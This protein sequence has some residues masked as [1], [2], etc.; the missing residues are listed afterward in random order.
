MGESE[1]DAFT[2]A[3]FEG[4]SVCDAPE[5]TGGF[6]NYVGDEETRGEE[7]RMGSSCDRYNDA[8][9]CN[10]EYD[11]VWD[12]YADSNSLMAAVTVAMC[13]RKRAV[14]QPISLSLAFM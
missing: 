3:D 5:H 4:E 1:G 14:L 2:C 10:A 11:C 13:C 7:D 8:D 6:C 9:S 12:A